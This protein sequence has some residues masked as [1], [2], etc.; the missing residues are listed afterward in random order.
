MA[1]QLTWSL[2]KRDRTRTIF[3]DGFA[4][5]TYSREELAPLIREFHALSPQ[6]KLTKAKELGFIDTN[7][8]TLPRLPPTLPPMNLP[9]IQTNQPSHQTNLPPGSPIPTSPTGRMA[10]FKFPKP[11]RFMGNPTNFQA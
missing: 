1:Q 7:P 9:L 6:K 11:L 5:E 8:E 10:T 4:S 3:A 2:F